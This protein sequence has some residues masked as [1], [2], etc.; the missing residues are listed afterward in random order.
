MKIFRCNLI[1]NSKK[2]IKCQKKFTLVSQKSLKQDKNF[3]FH[4]F[5]K[6]KKRLDYI[7]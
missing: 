1:L 5:L 4:Y 3:I 7:F 6:I 2:R